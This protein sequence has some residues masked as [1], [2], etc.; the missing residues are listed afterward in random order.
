MNTDLPVK[1]NKMNEYFDMIGPLPAL[2]NFRPIIKR[3]YVYK[4]RLSIFL[5]L[6][7]SKYAYH[8]PSKADNFRVFFCRQNF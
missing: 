3:H 8:T 6:T 2:V 5:K 1:E 4:L 7:L